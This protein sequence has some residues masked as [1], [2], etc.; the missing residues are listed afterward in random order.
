E[1]AKLTFNALILLN[2]GALIGI[3]TFLGSLWRNNQNDAAEQI[4]RGIASSIGF[5]IAGLLL[6]VLACMC[7]YTLQRLYLEQDSFAKTVETSM[8]KILHVVGSI[9]VFFSVGFF[10]YG[11]WI[12]INAFVPTP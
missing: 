12:G 2:G 4:A 1:L 11:A 10:G 5:F 7:A 6:T 8:I 3:L 9:F